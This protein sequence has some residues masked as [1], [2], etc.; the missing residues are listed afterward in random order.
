VVTNLADGR[1][2][3]GIGAALFFALNAVQFVLGL[4]LD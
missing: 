4:L 1:A 3:G 2:L